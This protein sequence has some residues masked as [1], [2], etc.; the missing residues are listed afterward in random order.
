MRTRVI[1]VVL[2]TLAAAA[3]GPAAVAHTELINSSPG[4]ADI[5]RDLSEV[6]LEFSDDLLEIGASIV[7]VHNGATEYDLAV[8]H[9]SSRV[10]VGAVPD[11]P[12]GEYQVRWR[13]VAEDGHPIDGTYVF[14]FEAPDGVEPSI[15]PSTVV[16]PTP[17]PTAI[18]ILEIGEP[19]AA[20]GV[21]PWLAALIALV[22]ATAIGAVW[23][24][25]IRSRMR[26]EL[27]GE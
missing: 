17:S 25:S 8:S 15:T 1:T 9:P 13:V 23:W 4:E 26:R 27:A 5:V 7:L 24:L 21:S 3:A 11:V 10:V 14:T 20:D 2:A 19:G 12:G 22:G 16:S 18:P 6:R